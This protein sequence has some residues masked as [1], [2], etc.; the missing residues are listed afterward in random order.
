MNARVKHEHSWHQ[1]QINHNWQFQK[2]APRTAREAFGHSLDTGRRRAD[3]W[4]FWIVVL[5]A[6]IAFVGYGVVP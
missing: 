1:G 3:A 6:V 5:G 4:V 2:T